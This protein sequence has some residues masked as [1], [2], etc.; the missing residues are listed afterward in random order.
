MQ[1]CY[2][3]HINLMFNI[4]TVIHVTCTFVCH[5]SSML[6]NNLLYL[7][8]LLT[9]IKLNDNINLREVTHYLRWF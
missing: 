9:M 3:E 8:H 6:S 2:A 5:N 7:S 4:V 1:T